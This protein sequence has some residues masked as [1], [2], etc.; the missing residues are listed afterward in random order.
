M[1]NEGELVVITDTYRSC[2]LPTPT[3]TI[4]AFGFEASRSHWTNVDV[5]PVTVFRV[6]H[7]LA[8]KRHGF[9]RYGRVAQATRA[10]QDLHHRTMQNPGDG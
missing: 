10:Q 9:F 4:T 6:A 2:V 3:K 1:Q 7:F 8:Y 5:F